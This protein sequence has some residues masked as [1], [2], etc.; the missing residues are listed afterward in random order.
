M[1]GRSPEMPALFY[2]DGRPGNCLSK[3]RAERASHNRRL[4]YVRRLFVGLALAI[5][6]P[7]RRSCQCLLSD[8]H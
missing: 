4:G 1:V 2:E 7:N 3:L 8:M 6:S 5:N